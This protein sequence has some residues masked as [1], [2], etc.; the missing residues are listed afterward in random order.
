MAVRRMAWK[1]LLILLALGPAGEAMAEQRRVALVIGNG[2][3]QHTTVLANAPN[4]GRAM[5]A[6]L[7]ALDFDVL[8]GIDL[9]RRATETL[10][11]DFS[12]RLDSAEVG[13]FFYAGH[14][15][16]VNGSNYLVPVDA[17]LETEADLD[18]ET[19]RLDI[20]LNQLER[21][22]RTN[23]VLLDACRDNPLARTLSR[24]MGASRSAAVG[25]GLARI[26]GGIGTLIAYATEPDNVALDGDGAN[27]PFTTALLQH[28]DTPG[29][30]VRQMLTRVRQQVIAATDRR[31]VPWDHSS[32]TG[33]F[34]FRPQTA[35]P[36]QI[37][38]PPGRDAELSLWDAAQ[39]VD[40]PEQKIEALQVYLDAYPDGAFARMAEIQ[41]TA[42]ELQ[43][44]QAAESNRGLAVQAIEPG[45]DEE[46]LG[47]TRERRRA[48]QRALSVLGFDTGGADGVFGPNSRRAITAFQSA[49]GMEPSGYLDGAQLAI[50]LEA[51]AQPLAEAGRQEAAARIETGSDDGSG[52]ADVE[53]W[54]YLLDSDLD[55]QTVR[56]IADSRHDMVVVDYLPSQQGSEDYPMAE[57]VRRWQQAAHPKLVLAYINIGEAENYRSYWQ[58]D[59]RIGNP[60]W[61]RGDDPDGWANNFP[62]AFWY[63]EWRAIW[64]A[65]GGLLN[66]IVAAGFDGVYL[67]WIGAYDEES[68]A[69]FAVSDGANAR[70]EMIWWVGDIAETAQKLNPDFVIIPQNPGELLEDPDFMGAIDGVAQEHV[71]FDGGEDNQP[72]GGCPLPRRDADIGSAA[73]RQSLSPACRRYH[74]DHPDGTLHASSER[75]LP[76]LSRARDSGKAVFT[77]DYALDADDIAWVTDTARR[78]GFVPFIGSRALDRFQAAHD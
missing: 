66:R 67:D 13:L 39:S 77:V 72:A 71:W 57:T 74:D 16:Q 34:F 45:A 59:W 76:N 64:L 3:Y 17:V 56:R 61:I 63:D 14:G 49:E 31:Q 32:L 78:Q 15:M 9:D 68:V 10:I 26:D 29:L 58:P 50:L 65:E 73:Y 4:D 46:A 33:D 47:L 25:R 37:A 19:V 51:A 12:R 40:L 7:R 62:I 69:D 38:A 43:L 42:M 48:I 28:I 1:I 53:R 20:I 52:L 21:R 6:K 44:A 54:L 41:T 22:P 35:A 5:A 60:D 24:S 36:V 27:S 8:E 55:P 11:R 30:E 70:Q 2:A 18:F 23:I 75:Y